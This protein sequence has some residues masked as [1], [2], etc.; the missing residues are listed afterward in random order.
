M[1]LWGVWERSTYS[2]ITLLKNFPYIQIVKKV[3]ALFS[4]FLQ[5]L[6]LFKI[7]MFMFS[8]VA[9][10]VS[11]SASFCY[12]HILHDICLQF[13]SVVFCYIGIK[14]VLIWYKAPLFLCK[15]ISFYGYGQQGKYTIREVS[16]CMQPKKNGLYMCFQHTVGF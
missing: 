9:L 4:S 15:T 10:H 13:V 14:L 11:A 1:L 2:E 8:F 7:S 12:T 5:Q 16:L 3:V 6:R